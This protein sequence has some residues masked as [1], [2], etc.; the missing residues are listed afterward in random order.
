MNQLLWQEFLRQEFLREAEA[1]P[2]KQK[3]K[4]F[5][6]TSMHDVIPDQGVIRRTLAYLHPKWLMERRTFYIMDTVQGPGIHQSDK[7]DRI[8]SIMLLIGILF[9]ANIK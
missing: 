5:F 7:F 8:F 9:Y 2:R 3:V 4:I 1:S 6:L